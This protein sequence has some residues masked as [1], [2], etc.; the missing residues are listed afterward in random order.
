MNPAHHV[1][2]TEA[3]Q[4]VRDEMNELF[5]GYEHE[6]YFIG[7]YDLPETM[8]MFVNDHDIDMIITMPKDHSWFSTLLGNTT[9]KNWRIKATSLFWLFINKAVPAGSPHFAVKTSA[10]KDIFNVNDLGTAN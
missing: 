8:N 7:L 6:F 2:I 9:R 1:S 4:K 5:K 3:Y 10:R